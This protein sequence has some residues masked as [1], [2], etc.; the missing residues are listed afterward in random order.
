LLP[1]VL[2]AARRW[3]CS[4]Q[5]W[6]GSLVLPIPG[7]LWGL[8]LSETLSPP[9]PGRAREKASDLNSSSGQLIC[10]GLLDDQ[11]GYAAKAWGTRSDRLL[12]GR[13]PAQTTAARSS[14][15]PASFP[16]PFRI[17]VRPCGALLIGGLQAW[18]GTI[19]IGSYSFLV[20]SSPAA[21]LW[22]LTT[23][24]AAPSTGTTSGRW[25]PATGCSD[26]LAHP[27]GDP[28]A[29]STLATCQE[30]RGSLEFSRQVQLRL[31]RPPK[32]LIETST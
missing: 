16:Y 15:R 31:R 18:R 11:E 7:V 32:D 23:L 6:P 27:N 21:A 13:L 25:P 29:V 20:F 10:A 19:A 14:S 3:R 8:D 22:P 1:L 26:W 30:V 28:K 5:G 12:S 9:L 17:S 24:G 4:P 2:G